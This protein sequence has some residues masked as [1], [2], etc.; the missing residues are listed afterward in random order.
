MALSALVIISIISGIVASIVMNS[1]GRSGAAGFFLGF[2]FSIIG[3]FIAFVLPKQEEKINQ[4]QIASG[5]MRECPA[6]K[7]V[8]PID[9]TKCRFCASDLPDLPDTRNLSDKKCD[10]CGEFLRVG[11]AICDNCEHINV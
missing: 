2:F 3:L 8:V 7:S 11:Y 4:K 6:C 1:K 5:K 10:K 9:A